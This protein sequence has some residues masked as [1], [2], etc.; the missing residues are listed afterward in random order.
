MSLNISVIPVIKVHWS[1][2]RKRAAKFK[3]VIWDEPTLSELT[4][5]VSDLALWSKVKHDFDATQP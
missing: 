1:L 4:K 5:T 2:H 3:T